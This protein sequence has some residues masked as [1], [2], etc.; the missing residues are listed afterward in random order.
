[1][2]PCLKK[3][4]ASTTGDICCVAILHKF[5]ISFLYT[6]DGPE[7]SKRYCHRKMIYYGNGV[8]QL[9]LVSDIRLILAI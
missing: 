3:E 7:I 8:E 5:V 4:K 2:L 9:L 1:M 6:R